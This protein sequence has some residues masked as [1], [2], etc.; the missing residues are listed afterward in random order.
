ME[1]D[2]RQ[3]CDR[4]REF[5]VRCL[6]AAVALDWLRRRPRDGADVPGLAKPAG[7]GRQVHPRSQGARACGLGLFSEL[8]ATDFPIA[9]INDSRH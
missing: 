3:H 1:S 7:V 2:P 4:I 8:A 5:R 6:G 9:D